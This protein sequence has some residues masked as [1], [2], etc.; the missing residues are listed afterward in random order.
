MSGLDEE[1]DNIVVEKEIPKYRVE[2]YDMKSEELMMK[3]I[4]YAAESLEKSINDKD[5]AFKLKSLLDKDQSLNLPS[6]PQGKPDTEEL[7]VWQVII[8][9][10]FT[11]SI[12][13]DAENLIYFKFQDLNKYFLVFRS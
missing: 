9:R 8:G 5:I 12:N 4:K 6:N 13:F 11:A 1:E 10:L 7:G 3:I 2:Y